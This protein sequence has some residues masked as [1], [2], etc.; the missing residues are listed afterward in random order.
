MFEC[1]IREHHFRTEVED[2]VLSVDLT[3]GVRPLPLPGERSL[4][5]A[6]EVLASAV[7]RIETLG[8]NEVN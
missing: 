7:V 1:E 3:P 4:D 6:I 2:I 8:V 5:V